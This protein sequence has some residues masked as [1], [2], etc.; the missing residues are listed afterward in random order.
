MGILSFMYNAAKTVSEV[1]DWVP[2][3]DTEKRQK[4]FKDLYTFVVFINAH[5]DENAHVLIL[6]DD[7]RIGMITKYYLYPRTATIAIDTMSF[8]KLLKN[9][10]YHLVATSNSTI[11]LED[12]EKIATYSSKIS[13]DF[14]ILY[15]LK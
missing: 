4:I 7:G 3:T 14:G 15:K 2:L 8:M 11:Q 10:K 12:Y 6:S 13:S 1:K 9:R 5:T